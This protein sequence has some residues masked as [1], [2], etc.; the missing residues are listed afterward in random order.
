MN[1]IANVR[2]RC[3]LALPILQSRGATVYDLGVSIYCALVSQYSN[4]LY[5]TV[6]YELADFYR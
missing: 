5:D 6:K 3:T 1:Q 4:I 2:S